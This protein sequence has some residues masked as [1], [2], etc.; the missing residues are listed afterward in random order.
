[1]ETVP[2]G[3]QANYPTPPSEPALM[4]IWKGVSASF[5]TFPPFSIHFSSL[6]LQYKTLFLRK[7]FIVHAFSSRNYINDKIAIC[8]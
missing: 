2:S 7:K 5:T 1:L 6:L 4:F 3:P 8:Q